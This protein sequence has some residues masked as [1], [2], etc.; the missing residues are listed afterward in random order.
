MKKT[1]NKKA[2]I[3]SIEISVKKVRRIHYKGQLLNMG[4]LT[5]QAGITSDALFKLQR[6]HNLIAC[7]RGIF[8]G[9][10][11]TRE[12]AESCVD[13]LEELGMDRDEFSILLRH[14]VMYNDSYLPDTTPNLSKG[15][16]EDYAQQRNKGF[17]TLDKANH[18]ATTR[19]NMYD[20]W[21]RD[22]KGKPVQRV[23]LTLRDCEG[24]VTLSKSNGWKTIK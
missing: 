8:G 19:Y 6:R 21:L 14:K 16:D 24:K 7:H 13:F 20:K 1:S 22:N 10:C 11:P 18:E 2:Y 3:Q 9:H 15:E 17:K 5:D 12:E 23:T 4:V